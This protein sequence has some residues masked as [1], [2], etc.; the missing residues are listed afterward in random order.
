[1]T[2]NDYLEILKDYLDKLNISEEEKRDV[3]RDIEEM[4][5]EGMESGKSEQEISSDL[6]SPKKII[7]EMLNSEDESL[8][9]SDL[10]DK[11]SS[12]T[13]DILRTSI[14]RARL[15]I[16]RLSFPRKCIRIIKRLVEAMWA[17]FLYGFGA[18]GALA[19]T[20]LAIVACLGIVTSIIMSSV[21]IPIFIGG[22]FASLF[23]I[24]SVF[25]GYECTI[26]VF[27]CATNLIT[28]KKNTAKVK[29]KTKDNRMNSQGKTNHTI[30]IKYSEDIDTK[31]E[32]ESVSEIMIDNKIELIEAEIVEVGNEHK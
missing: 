11:E 22:L 18:C 21:H 12:N 25:V 19:T 4:F 30:D 29:T 20:G 28:G 14:S 5:L 7:E 23:F 6:G 13:S 8:Y 32:V 15:E 26:G 10:E 24:G 27:E 1:M 2:K 16:K 3:M 17:L 31:D 9:G